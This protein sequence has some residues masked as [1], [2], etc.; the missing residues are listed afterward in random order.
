MKRLFRRRRYRH[1][2]LWVRRFF[3]VVLCLFVLSLTT[4]FCCRPIVTEFGESQAVWLATRIANETVA[5]V[6]AQH[7]DTCHSMIQ[8]SYNDQQV[9]ASVFTDTGAVNTIRTAITAEVMRRM[10]GISSI[11]VGVPLGTLAGFNWLSGWGPPVQFP[12]SVT[13][14]VLSNVSSSLEAAGINQTAYRVLVHLEISLTVVTPGGRSSVAA[15][16]SYPMAETVLLGEV[17]DNLTEVYGDDQTL[18]GK[19]FDYGAGE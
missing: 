19:I 5:D 6:L 12:M 4:F 1:G 14:T 18:L 2:P 8:V 3:C 13:A 17:P 9:L 16:S 15:T 7:G 10:E 11:T